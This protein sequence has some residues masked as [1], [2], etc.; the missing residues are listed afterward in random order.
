MATLVAGANAALTG[1][2]P[3]LDHVVV[4]MGWDAI[5]SRGPQAELVPFAVMCDSSGQALSNDHL[6]YFNQL[7]SADA[8][9]TFIDDDDQEQI[10]VEL[11]QVPANISKIIFLAY[12][13]PE[14]R[15]QGTFASVRSAHIRVATADN[16]ELVRFDLSVTNVDSVTAMIFGELYRHRDDWKFRALGQGYTTGLAG[17]A[18]DYGISL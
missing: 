7:V 5:P 17:V 13:D 2:N 9:V 4:G 15:G 1:E 10:D 3:G 6:V 8:S 12:V 18:K 16:R 14:F 11:S